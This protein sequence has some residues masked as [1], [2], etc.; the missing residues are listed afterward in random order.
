MPLADVI[1]RYQF[2][3]DISPRNAALLQAAATL[4]A[5]CLEPQMAVNGALWLLCEIERV[6]H[7]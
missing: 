1:D 6:P 4:Q 7:E 5:S 2:H 3:H